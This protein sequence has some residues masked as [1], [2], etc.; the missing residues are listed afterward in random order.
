MIMIIS[1]VHVSEQSILQ[2]GRCTVFRRLFDKR[3]SS[4]Y[5]V[6]NTQQGLLRVLPS[7]VVLSRRRSVVFGDGFSA[8]NVNLG[9][10]DM[11]APNKNKQ[12]NTGQ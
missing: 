3:T 9:E 4:G 12:D 7:I 10:L 6:T 2:T 5:D 11:V 8:Q 1:V